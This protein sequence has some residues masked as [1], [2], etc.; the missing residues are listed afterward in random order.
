ML[1]SRKKEEII[2]RLLAF[3]TSAPGATKK[4]AAAASRNDSAAPPAGAQDGG[5]DDVKTPKPRAK[6]GIG[7]VTLSRAQRTPLPKEPEEENA[8]EEKEEEEEAGA[9][10]PQPMAAGKKRD[11][12]GQVLLLT[13]LTVLLVATGVTLCQRN[14]QCQ[15][16]LSALRVGGFQLQQLDMSKL[17]AVMQESI[18]KAKEIV[19]QV[20]IQTNPR[21]CCLGDGMYICAYWLV[22]W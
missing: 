16:L 20:S 4:K 22:A 5:K 21:C 9:A 14:P 8:E 7:R 11:V 17:Y 15:P 1:G 13:L 3:E 6:R 2:E 19:A 12:V 10:A 18:Q